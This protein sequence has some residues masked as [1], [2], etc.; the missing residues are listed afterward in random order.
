MQE[1]RQCMGPSSLR[2][3]FWGT[4]GTFY[5]QQ[6]GQN[7]Q[8]E[9]SFGAAKANSLHLPWSTGVYAFIAMNNFQWNNSGKHAT[10]AS[11]SLLYV[12][13]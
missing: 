11:L 10:N 2:V 8:A 9:C 5:G 12:Q 1:A 13:F 3:G 6:A 4:Q 7:D